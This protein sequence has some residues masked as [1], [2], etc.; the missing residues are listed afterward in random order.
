MSGDF[1]QRA[2]LLLNS[3][4][5]D[6]ALRVLDSK[7]AEDPSNAAAHGLMALCLLDMNEA[8]R[9]LESA[10]RAS[11]EAPEW[12]FPRYVHANVL[13]RMG[14][15]KNALLSAQDAVSLDPEDPNY[16]AL[17]A[18]CYVAMSQ[19]KE[20]LVSAECGLE[21]D[22]EDDRCTNLRALCLRQLGEVDEA[23]TAL[24]VSLG[25]D[26]DNAWTFQN[27]GFAA[28][29][30]GRHDEAIGHFRES[31]RLDPT[32]DASRMGLATSIKAKVPLFRPLIA[33]QMYCSRLSARF[34]MGLI[35][36]FWVLAQV[37]SRTFPEGSLLGGG[38][39][40]AY[41]SFVW[42]SWAGDALF[43]V[44]L[45]IK[46][47]LRDLLNRREKIASLG[48]IF[49]I[50]LA[51]SILALRVA[52]GLPGQEWHALTAAFAAIPMGGWANLPNGKARAIG[53]TFASVAL[54]AILVAFV[55]QLYVLHSTGWNMDARLPE[56]E[57]ARLSSTMR[58]S[59]TLQSISLI[60]SVVSSWVLTGLGLVPESKG[61]KGQRRRPR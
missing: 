23:E 21:L 56:G 35:L 54:G 26:P 52:F 45:L 47:E 32:D 42:L 38:L 49:C 58:R 2:S 17:V 20:G 18:S 12:G 3:G 24:R 28:L 30:S 22:P 34:G 61:G 13:L 25:H 60:T 29:Q 53:V 55:I 51:A 33:W 44:V 1:A 8:P 4:R 19:W 11:G 37:V 7:L 15:A 43:D 46:S 41:A 57:V 27:L 6:E 40:I 59:A 9:A 39:L 36:G 14:K 5:P 16:H 50:L 31:L 48:V 10:E